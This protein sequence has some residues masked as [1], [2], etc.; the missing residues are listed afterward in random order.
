M[1]IITMNDQKKRIV[2]VGI[3]KNENFDSKTLVN[4]CDEKEAMDKVLENYKNSLGVYFQQEDVTVAPFF[5][6]FK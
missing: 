3:I 2:Y 5:E 6:S 1:G 4:A